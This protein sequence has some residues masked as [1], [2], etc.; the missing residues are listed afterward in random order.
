MHTNRTW[1][2]STARYTI[3]K[4]F[5]FKYSFIC[6]VFKEAIIFLYNIFNYYFL[7][8]YYFACTAK[9]YVSKNSEKI[10]K[11]EVSISPILILIISKWCY[12]NKCFHQ[13]EL[14]FYV[15]NEIMFLHYKNT[16]TP[17]F[18]FSFKITYSYM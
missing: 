5:N 1:P 8:I 13:V 12:K 6:I 11:K 9:K 18:C 10:D 15:Y 17:L 16:C 14:S 4:L 3:F 2:T 7:Y